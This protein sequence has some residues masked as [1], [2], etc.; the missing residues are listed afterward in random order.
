M[1]L[2]REDVHNLLY[3][4]ETTLGLLVIDVEIQLGLCY[5]L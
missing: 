5:N 4:R 2:E 1:R 3:L